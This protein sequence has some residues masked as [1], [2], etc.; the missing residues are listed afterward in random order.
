MVGNAHRKSQRVR[1]GQVEGPDR[2][3]KLG[4]IQG[5]VELISF[6]EFL[7]VARARKVRVPSY[8]ST[9]P[10]RWDHLPLTKWET[11]LQRELDR[12]IPEE[13]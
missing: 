12:E 3:H 11:L 8:F 4:G 5:H 9:I 7:D 13:D 6:D 1:D 2:D 10:Q